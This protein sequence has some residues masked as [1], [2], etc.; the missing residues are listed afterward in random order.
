MLCEA[1]KSVR[2]NLYFIDSRIQGRRNINTLPI[3]GGLNR[4]LRCQ[5]LER[6]L[7]ILNHG[8]AAVF[9]NPGNDTPLYLGNSKRRRQSNQCQRM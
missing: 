2:R 4:K 9:H 7:R 3:R 8:P 6:H 1:S 5:V